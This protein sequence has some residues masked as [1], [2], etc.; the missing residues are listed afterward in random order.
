LGAKAIYK[1]IRNNLQ[2]RYAEHYGFYEEVQGQR[3]FF[4]DRPYQE[5]VLENKHN[6]DMDPIYRGIRLS[7]V[8]HRENVWRFSFS[9]LANIGMGQ[10]AFGNGASSNDFALLAES[11]A[12]PNSWINGYGRVDGDRGYV[13]K[14]HYGRYLTPDLYLGLSFKYRDG[15]PFAFINT[16]ERHDQ[17][18]LTYDTIKA[19]DEKGVKGGPREDYVSDVSLQLTYDFSLFD[20]EA[21]LSLSIFNLFDAG[22]E[23]SEYVFSGGERDSVELQIPRSL[24]LTFGWRL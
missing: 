17:I 20:K 23:L 5:F 14:C 8:G 6:R 16:V 19:E 4:F 24:R 12:N 18:V 13:A 11:Q 15:T 3:L 21:Q 22:S 7:I 10:T 9:F 1:T 2:V